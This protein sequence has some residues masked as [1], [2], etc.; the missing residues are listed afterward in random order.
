[1]NTSNNLNWLKNDEKF[2]ELLRKLS[3]DED[4]HEEGYTYLLSCSVLLLKEYSRD[5]RQT[6]YFEF[7]YFII[8]TYCLKTKNYSPLFDLTT[9]IGFYPISQFILDY[10]LYPQEQLQS[11]LVNQKLARFRNNEIIET[12]EQNKFRKEIIYSEEYDS[13]Y[14]APTSFGKSS[15]IVDLIHNL[16]LD[17][18]AIIVPTKSLL[19]Q[20]YRLVNKSFENKKII[21]H[22][23]MYSGENEF[24]AV[25]TQERA[26]RLLKDKSIHF[27][28]LIIDEAHN[29][30]EYSHRSILLS[31]LLRKNRQRLSNA[32]SFYFSP[33]ITN[34]SNL[35]IEEHQEITDRHI[36]FNIKEAQLFEYRLDGTSHIYNR[37]INKFFY[38][39]KYRDIFEYIIEHK[40]ENN[41]IYLRAPKKVEI[42]AS[43]LSRE[44][45]NIGNE[46]LESLAETISKNVHDE[47]YCVDLVKKG[48]LYLHGKLPDLVKEYLEYKFREIPE[49]QF[50]I[51]NSVIL[52]GVNLPIDNLYILNTYAL[53]GKD[54]TNLI[55]RV[56]RLNE[57]FGGRNPSL[58]KLKPNIH[59]VNSEQFNKKNS[60]MKNKIELLKS[61]FF[62][63]EVKNPTL[64]SFD[65]KKLN[66]TIENSRSIDAVEKASR[67]L[68][69]ATGIKKREDFLINDAHLEENSF[70]AAFIEAGL[71]IAYS[72]PDDIVESIS[73]RKERFIL[74]Q[75]WMNMNVIDKVYHLF[76]EGL[77]SF[78]VDRAFVRLKNIKARNYYRLFVNSIHTLSLKEHINETVNYFLAISHTSA[79][80]EFYIGPSYGELAKETY[81][82]E[83]TGNKAYIDIS[84]KSH[85]ELVN[86]A[87]I[88]IKMEGDYVS[89][90]LNEYVS[91]LRDIKLAT[92]D[93]YNL[94]IYGTTKKRNTNF[95]KLGLSGALINKLE[96]DKQLDNIE[97]SDL[98]HVKANED[99]RKYLLMQDDLM[100]FE[101][102]KYFDV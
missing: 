95:T 16:D 28:A 43:L 32:R 91:L 41:F 25:F 15:L 10:K 39:K 9:N 63:D 79:G 53:K 20:T 70:K 66:H 60:N 14:V 29:L 54:L 24:I 33:L 94:F 42:F 96:K 26:L 74:D 18:I 88:K 59:F 27:D 71:H 2:T 12:F 90:K 84:T 100:Q 85:K 52:E 45:D 80:K 87:L 11:H 55:G 4:I 62:K 61:G 99:F 31:R 82:G 1:M 13:C 23:E 78:I 93:E 86:I 34:A 5:N 83:Y 38:I 6:T 49:L 65:F 69:E 56:N 58:H 92:E 3:L 22:D 37:F 75:R 17:K 36:K 8:L 50:I 89:Y 77:E 97:I 7:S 81:D 30:F 35:K 64:L 67:N 51:A 21:F 48:I 47:F 101:V 98:G 57:V 68:E 19:T 72:E 76:I 102:R 44:L 46:R 40:A 73:K